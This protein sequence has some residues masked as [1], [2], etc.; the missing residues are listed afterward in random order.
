MYSS[1]SRLSIQTH[2]EILQQQSSIYM[3]T[4]AHLQAVTQYDVFLDT[5]NYIYVLE[6]SHFF[7]F[8]I[9]YKQ[10]VRQKSPDVC[11][12]HG[13]LAIYASESL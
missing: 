7:L 2:Y 5:I 10:E 1:R 9:F 13:S 12:E 11:R 4:P 8:F 6:S 3:S